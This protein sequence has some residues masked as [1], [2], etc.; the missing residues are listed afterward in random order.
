[1]RS[2]V[3][4]LRRARRNL[5]LEHGAFPPGHFYSPIPDLAVADELQASE[6]VAGPRSLPGIEEA[7]DDQL[8]LVR[9]LATYYEELPFPHQ[10]SEEFRYFYDNRYYTYSD[11]IFLYGMLRHLRPRRVVEVGAG[12]SSCVILDTNE[13]FLD[14][15]TDVTLIEPYPKRFLRLVSQHPGGYRLIAEPVQQADPNALASLS[16]GD[17]LVIDS[18]HVVKTGSDVNFLVFQ[19]LPHLPVGVYV[20]VHDVFYPFEYPAEWVRQGKFWSE[21]YLL[22]A[23]LQYNSA[24]RIAVMNHGVAARSPELL[25]ELMPLCLRNTGGSLWIHRT[26]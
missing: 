8:R 16:A 12:Y 18:S 20:H 25:K 22:R 2:K 21:A 26:A 5:L 3:R 9:E 6:P 4:R 19:V 24:F 23:F 7:Y 1:M 15:N 10:R 14:G 17:V 13:R 11:A